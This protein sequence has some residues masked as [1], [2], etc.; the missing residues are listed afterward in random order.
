MYRDADIFVLPSWA[1]GL[2]NAMIEAMAA[3]VAVVVSSVGNIPDVVSDGQNAVLVRPKD[4]GALVS[5]LSHLIVDQERRDALAENGHFLADAEFSVEVAVS[6][7]LAAFSRASDFRVG[8]N[9]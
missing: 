1:E 8:R 4:T 6:R 5:A 7:L 2:P 9:K 3:R